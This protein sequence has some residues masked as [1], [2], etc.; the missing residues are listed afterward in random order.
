MVYRHPSMQLKQ[1]RPMN[2][3]RRELA[4]PESRWSKRF[5]FRSEFRS[6]LR[7][8]VRSGFR[9]KFRLQFLVLPGPGQL[10]LLSTQSLVLALAQVRCAEKI[11]RASC[12]DGGSVIEGD[13]DW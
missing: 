10:L 1:L 8:K 9:R 5:Q 11:G 3:T 4:L 7:W 12:R 13:G 6:G 2:R